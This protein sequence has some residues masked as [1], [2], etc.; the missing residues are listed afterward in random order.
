MGN[1]KPVYLLAPGVEVNDIVNMTAMAVFE[2]QQQKKEFVS[3]GAGV[4]DKQLA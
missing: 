2:A 1:R 4:R 3:V